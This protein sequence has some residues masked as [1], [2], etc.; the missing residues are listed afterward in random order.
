MFSAV[1]PAPPQP[2]LPVSLFFLFARIRPSARA[3]STIFGA[4]APVIVVREPHIRSAW[5]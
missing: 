4:N 1:G 5:L 2:T 3:C